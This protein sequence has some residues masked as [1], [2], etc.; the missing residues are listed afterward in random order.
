MTQSGRASADPSLVRTVV[1]GLERAGVLSSKEVVVTEASSVPY[2]YI[3]FDTD[4]AA[5][6]AAALEG[7]AALGLHSVGRFGRFEYIN[8]DQCIAR[9]RA[10]AREILGGKPA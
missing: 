1:E 2:A 4:Y 6:I 5:K 3:V 8:S 9:A 10:L 7:V